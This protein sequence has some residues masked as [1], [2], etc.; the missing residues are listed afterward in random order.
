MHLQKFSDNSVVLG[1]IREGEEG[2]YR[3][4]VGGFVEWSEENHL[5]LN[6]DKIREMV[7]DFR[8]KKMP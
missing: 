1:C 4:L 2:E 8:K 6:D 7:I 5:R 3:T